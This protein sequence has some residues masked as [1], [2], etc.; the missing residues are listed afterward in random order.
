MISLMRDPKD[1]ASAIKKLRAGRPQKDIAERAGFDSSTWSVYEKGKRLPRDQDRFEQIARGLGCTLERLDEV[2]W[3]CRNERV[4]EE[5]A[6]AAPPPQAPVTEP[7]LLAD[8]VD[9]LKSAIQAGLTNIRQ[10]MNE[11]LEALEDVLLLAADPNRPP[12]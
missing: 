9:P 7:A 3:E 4:G 8:R 10:G 1:L 2:I 12:S 11:V 5:Q 6:K